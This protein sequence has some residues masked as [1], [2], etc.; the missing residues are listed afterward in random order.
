MSG[1]NLKK[2][3]TTASILIPIVWSASLFPESW[4]II[5]FGILRKLYIT[6]LGFPFM[7]I[8]E[9][10]NIMQKTLEY[11]GESNDNKFKNTHH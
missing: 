2:R 7:A 10:S 11:V 4:Y 5:N 6:F 8:F 9:Y 3:L 1:V